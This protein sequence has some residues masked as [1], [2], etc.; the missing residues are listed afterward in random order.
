MEQ[1]DFKKEGR[2]AK[3]LFCEDDERIVK[4]VQEL[5]EEGTI[6]P[7][8]VTNNP[9]QGIECITIKPEEYAEQYY[10]IRQHK[11]ISLEDAR[12][13]LEHPAFYAS[14]LLANGR[15]DGLVC[16]A[17]WP[18]ADTIRPALHVLRKGLASST[19]LME[20]N[21]GLY[22]FADCAFNVQPNAAELAQI[23]I[24]SAEVAQR[25]GI[26]PKIAMLSFSTIGSAS[27]PDQKKVA[28]ATVLVA[29]HIAQHQK[30]WVVSGEYQ[31][32]AAMVPSVAEKKAP[33]QAIKGDANVFI[34]PDLDAGNIG[35]KLVQRFTDSEAIGPIL[36]G[37]TKPVNDLSRGC[38]V[39]EIKQV[40]YITAWQAKSSF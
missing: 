11:G 7:I 6:T 22:V 34:F 20:T 18:T 29:E 25:L 15:A 3:I 19:M 31:V 27:H 14:I 40:A 35:Y 21:K 12:K 5:Q 8:L 4:A 28:D 13:T 17:S 9:I 30:D 2:G 26:H 33:G 37:F 32:D 36:T 24:N 39:N 23:A 38:T 1:V 16:G 10:E